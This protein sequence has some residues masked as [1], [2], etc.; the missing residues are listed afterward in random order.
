VG[1]GDGVGGNRRRRR[2]RSMQ[3]KPWVVLKS[4]KTKGQEMLAWYNKELE[5]LLEK[6]SAFG[7]RLKLLV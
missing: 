2:E 6:H 1:V 4:F 3:I 5:R 7:I